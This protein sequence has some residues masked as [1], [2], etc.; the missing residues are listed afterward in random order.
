[1]DNSHRTHGLIT[2]LMG[3]YVNTIDSKNDYK[4]WTYE[5]EEERVRGSLLLFGIGVFG[6]QLLKSIIHLQSFCV[7]LVGWVFIIT[8]K[9][10][11]ETLFLFN[12]WGV[13]K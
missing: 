12:V 2:L 1:M 10:K 9:G 13:L 8:G 4:S 3:G 6:V 5:G 7:V 11:K